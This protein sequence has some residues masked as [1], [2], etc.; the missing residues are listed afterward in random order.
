VPVGDSNAFANAMIRLLSDH[1][2]ARKMG[3]RALELSKTV[4]GWENIARTVKRAY[5]E[6]CPVPVD[7]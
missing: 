3:G 1:E 4:Y 5:M 7:K 2:L 6:V